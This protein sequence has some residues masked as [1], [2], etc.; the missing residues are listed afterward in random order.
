MVTSVTPFKSDFSIDEEGIRKNVRFLVDNGIDV[1]TPCGSIGEW[2]SLTS[3]ELGRVVAVSVDEANGGA[4]VL[5]GA[6]STSTV[7]AAKRARLVEE[8]G[9]DGL[10]VTPP[11]YMK[12]T[13]DGLVRH[14]KTVASNTSLP[15]VLYNAPDF[16]GFELTTPDLAKVVEE[17]ESVVAIKDATTDMLEFANRIRVLQ[18]SEEKRNVRVILG[19]EPYCYHGLVAGSYGTFNSVGNFAPLPMQQMYEAVQE[20]DLAEARKIYL[21]LTEYF[22]FRRR[23]KNPIGVVKQSMIKSGIGIEPFVR[24]PLSQ[25][26]KSEIAELEIVLEHLQ[27]PKIRA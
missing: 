18:M 11:F 2:S 25:L 26:S 22:A 19:N 24:P 16:L 4:P 9:A 14:F 21:K 7:E 3:E 5:A 6:S 23:T 1:V 15:I 17:V 10:L 20:G 12:Y 13:L 8:A 27:Q